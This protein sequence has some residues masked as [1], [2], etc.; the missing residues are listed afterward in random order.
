MMYRFFP[1]K[2]STKIPKQVTIEVGISD[3]HYGLKGFL[4]KAKTGNHSIQKLKEL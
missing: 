4:Q 3:S 1:C 2:L